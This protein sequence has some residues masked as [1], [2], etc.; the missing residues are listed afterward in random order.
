MNT[1]EKCPWETTPN[2]IEA[3]ANSILQ[4]HIWETEN[5]KK[6]PREWCV[7][8][9]SH[10]F[11]DLMLRVIILEQRVKAINEEMGRA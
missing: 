8:L 6:A 3:M 11:Q 9:T 10:V 7:I 1:N 4:Q 5:D 2:S